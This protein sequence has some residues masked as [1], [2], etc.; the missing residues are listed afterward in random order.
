MCLLPPGS[1]P[2][3]ARLSLLDQACE[4]QATITNY[5][6]HAACAARHESS[7]NGGMNNPNSYNPIDHIFQ[8]HKVNGDS[9]LYCSDNLCFTSVFCLY[10]AQPALCR[11]PTSNP[12]VAIVNQMDNNIHM[13]V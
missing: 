2:K 13:C 7:D 9:S 12:P 10:F 1:S 11:V 5:D 4:G 6:M 8:F 3:R